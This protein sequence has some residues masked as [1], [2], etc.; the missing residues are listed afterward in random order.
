LDQKT[1]DK[2]KFDLNLNVPEHQKKENASAKLLFRNWTVAKIT[3][4]VIY[5]WGYVSMVYYF[6]AWGTIP[7]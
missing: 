1:I 3:I 7:G 6:L 5:L 4:K 2:I